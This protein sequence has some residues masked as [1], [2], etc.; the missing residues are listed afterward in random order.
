MAPKGG[1]GGKKA[2]TAAGAGKESSATTAVLAPTPVPA[3]APLAVGNII[4]C[5]YGRCKVMKRGEAPGMWECTPLS[6]SLAQNCLP[7]FH[8]NESSMQPVPLCVG[9]VI[10]CNY[11]GMGRIEEV[12]ASDFVVTLDNWKL[13][14]G[15]SPRLYLARDAFTVWTSL[16]ARALNGDFKAG[17][18]KGN[19]K[20]EQ[21]TYWKECIARAT[22]AKNEATELFKNG[23]LAEAKSKYLQALQALEHMG[24]EDNIPDAL[25]AEVYETTVPCHNNV[26]TCSLKLQQ[27][28]DAM[29]FARNGLLLT[30]AMQG[31]IGSNMWRALVERGLSE[32]KLVKDWMK[33]S[34]YLLAK[35]EVG[36][37]D[38][39]EACEHLEAAIKL[40]EGD[41]EYE[42]NA[43][44]LRKALEEANVA[45]KQ[46]LKKDK[47]I[48]GGSFKKMKQEEEQL[49][50][51]K[52]QQLERQKKSPAKASGTG[53]PKDAKTIADSVL[54][55][56]IG[57]G[58]KGESD[59]NDGE[60]QPSLDD[61][62]N[63]T[64]NTAVSLVV[65]AGLA[66]GAYY[67]GKYLSSSRR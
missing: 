31:R 9:D 10:K 8:L 6:W 29:G 21:L 51:E 4:D 45:R 65:V 43:A 14:Q 26:S 60:K 53:G 16:D 56:L 40:V 48:W 24:D 61:A 62:E 7:H 36:L 27:F 19:I 13:A 52:Q 11:G 50:K 20:R 39:D 46:Q 58:S 33:K 54:S 5:P 66:A 42:K 47:K 2:Q 38:F 30:R 1:K 23:A 59:D 37:K 18:G 28:S 57:G 67:L 25:R 32:D 49:E 63:S 15:Q 64:F 22:T 55:S 35:A 3:S 34:L 41:K 17:G 44:E 12:R